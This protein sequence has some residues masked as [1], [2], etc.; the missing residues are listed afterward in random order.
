MTLSTNGKTPHVL[1][2][3]IHEVQYCHDILHSVLSNGLPRPVEDIIGLD[4]GDMSDMAASLNVLCWLL[5]HE[6]SS[7]LTNILLLEEALNDAG[8]YFETSETE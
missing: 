4:E 8:I 3:G 5:G 1:P 6:G 7:F 2:V